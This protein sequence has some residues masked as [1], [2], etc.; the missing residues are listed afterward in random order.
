MFVPGGG[1][2]AETGDIVGEKG[3][4]R[5]RGGFGEVEEEAFGNGKGSHC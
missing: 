1:S 3:R 5:G 2:E 4:G